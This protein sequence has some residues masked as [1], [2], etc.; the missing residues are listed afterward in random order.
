VVEL[1]ELVD[2]GYQVSVQVLPLG[3][4]PLLLL[5]L[6]LLLQRPPRRRRR[7]RGGASG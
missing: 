5:L 1:L 3:R 4:R 2:G 7:R 6:L